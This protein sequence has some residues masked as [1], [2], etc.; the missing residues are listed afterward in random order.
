MN[1]YIV[2]QMM[3]IVFTMQQYHAQNVQF[4]EGNERLVLGFPYT[5]YRCNL[6]ILMCYKSCNNVHITGDLYEEKNG[7]NTIILQVKT[8]YTMNSTP[9]NTKMNQI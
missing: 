8:H 7:D 6:R 3:K 9:M 1:V 2:T 5:L 4:F